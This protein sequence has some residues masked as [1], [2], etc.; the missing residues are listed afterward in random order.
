[1]SYDLGAELLNFGAFIAFMGVNLVR[2]RPLLV[3]GGEED[4]S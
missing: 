1:M 3:A 2:A 4:R